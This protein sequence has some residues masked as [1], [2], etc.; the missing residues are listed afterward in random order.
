MGVYG[1]VWNSNNI[2]RESLHP[3]SRGCAGVHW[4]EVTAY[5]SSSSTHDIKY[6]EA[7]FGTEKK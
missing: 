5:I 1:R 6:L 2:C 3:I 7:N 4:C